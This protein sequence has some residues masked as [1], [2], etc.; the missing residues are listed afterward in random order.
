MKVFVSGANGFVGNTLIRRLEESGFD[1]WAVVRQKTLRIKEVVL[2]LGSCSEDE[3]FEKLEGA[4]CVVHLAANA[5]F[6]STFVEEIYNINCLANLAIANVMR[7]HDSHFIFASNALIAGMHEEYISNMSDDNPAIPYNISKYISEQYIIKRLRNYCILRIGGIYGY[8]GPEH[9]YLNRAISHAI[10]N[11]QLLSINN[12]G[13][14][15]RNYIYVEDLCSW[16]IHI[17]RN[18]TTGKY[19]IAGKEILS[20]KDIFLHINNV[21]L[22]GEGQLSLNQLGKSTDQIIESTPPDIIMHDYQSALN[23]IKYK[24]QNV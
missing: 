18:K 19:L 23:D 11:N 14:G 24:L 3:I 7:R 20:L 12:D 6:S 2:N 16:I 13:L 1:T 4:D 8:N 9:L 5:D 10:N 21:L 17:I 22:G 15:R